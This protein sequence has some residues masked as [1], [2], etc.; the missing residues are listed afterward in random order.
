M[1]NPDDLRN[2]YNNAYVYFVPSTGKAV[3]HAL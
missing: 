1:G 3:Y 2:N